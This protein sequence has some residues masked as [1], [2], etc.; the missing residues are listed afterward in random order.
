V[1]WTACSLGMK[2]FG[3]SGLIIANCIN[4][5]IRTLGS[6]FTMG[7]QPTLILQ[8]IG[9]KIFVGIVSLGLVANLVIKKIV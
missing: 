4:M 8:C 2:W 9:S 7:I 5:A 3:V 1:Y 6:M